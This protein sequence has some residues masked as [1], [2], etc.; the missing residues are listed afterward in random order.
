MGRVFDESLFTAVEPPLIGRWASLRTVGVQLIPS[1]TSWAPT[2]L[3]D[4]VHGVCHTRQLWD[5]GVTLL[6][7]VGCLANMSVALTDA[8]T[9]E[10]R[11]SQR[12]W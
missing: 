12:P 11:P 9:L 3:K 4:D 10:P 1:L 7:D 6:N 8:A 2:V 5:V